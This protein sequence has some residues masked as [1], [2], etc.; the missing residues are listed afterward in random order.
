M[1]EFLNLRSV[2]SRYIS[3]IQDAVTKVLNKGKYIMGEETALFEEEFALYIG[4]NY[5]IGVASGLDA[6]ALIINSFNF[7][8]GDEIIVPANTFIASILAIIQNN[9]TP[10]LVEPDIITFN[11]DAGK[12]EKKNHKQDQSDNGCTFVWP[13]CAHGCNLFY[14]I[15]S[16]TESY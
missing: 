3:E 15:Q 12:I 8:E 1:I 11:I 2:N 10:V 4:V 5:A 7:E 13:P 6:L 14:R 9:C 16:W